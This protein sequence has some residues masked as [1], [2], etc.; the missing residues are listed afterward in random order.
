MPSFGHFAFSHRAHHMLSLGARKTLKESLRKWRNFTMVPAQQS[1][2]CICPEIQDVA[3]ANLP[4]PRPQGSRPHP[5]FE[6]KALGTRLNLPGKLDN[7]SFLNKTM[8][9]SL[10]RHSTQKTLRHLRTLT[11]PLEDT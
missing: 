4:Q 7:S 8:I 5:F 3:R 6:G 2:Q 9:L 10:L 1:V 11:S